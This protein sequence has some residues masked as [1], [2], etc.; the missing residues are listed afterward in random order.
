MTMNVMPKINSDEDFLQDLK[1]A[2]LGEAYAGDED[3][4]DDYEP[5][6]F[7]IKLPLIAGSGATVDM[8]EDDGEPTLALKLSDGAMELLLAEIDRHPV[9]LEHHPGRAETP[10]SSEETRH[11]QK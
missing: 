11:G 5:G 4:P 8:P 1:I 7:Q 10:D 3:L 9:G 2:I 6:Q